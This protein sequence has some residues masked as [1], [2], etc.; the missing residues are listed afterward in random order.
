MDRVETAQLE[1]ELGDVVAKA[2]IGARC[3]VEQLAESTGLTAREIQSIE[4]YELKPDEEQLA[5]I[6]D[7][8]SLD[9]ERLAEIAADAWKPRPIDI[10][11]TNAIVESVVVPYG[12]YSSNCYVIGC[13]QTRAAAVVDPGGAVDQ[14]SKTLKEHQ[15]TPHFVL[16]THAH[17]DHIG[18]IRTFASLWPEVWVVSHQVE[19]DSVTRGLR[20]RWEAA[21]DKVSFQVGNLTV[22]PLSTPGHTPGSTCYHIDGVCLVGDTLFAGS[23]GRPGGTEGYHQML[24]DIRAKVLSLPDQTI[25]LPGHGPPTTVGEEKAHNPFF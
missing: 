21:K 12:T 25:L 22:T 10:S 3:T 13:A 1:D 14:I 15:L 9:R 8:L 6:A 11:R 24:M 23:V 4:S 17:G 18:G 7:A 2:R 5:E 20:V 16:V 19:R